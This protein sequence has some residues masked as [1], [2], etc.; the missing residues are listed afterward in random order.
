MWIHHAPY[1]LRATVSGV[2]Q[3]PPRLHVDVYSLME[4]SENAGEAVLHYQSQL[5]TTI[6]RS[7]EAQILAFEKLRSSRDTTMVPHLLVY[8]AVHE[9][10]E[11]H[12]LDLETQVLV[13]RIGL[14]LS[15]LQC[16]NKI[17]Q[18]DGSSLM[19]GM[20]DVNQ[21][22]ASKDLS[23]VPAE[24][25]NN[26]R[27]FF[28]SYD[29]QDTSDDTASTS[30]ND[31]LTHIWAQTRTGELCFFRRGI[32]QWSHALAWSVQ[33]LFVRECQTTDR[34]AQLC[35]IVHMDKL[36]H[37]YDAITGRLLKKWSIIDSDIVLSDVRHSGVY[38]VL[39]LNN[40]HQ[41][42][43]LRCHI[44][45]ELPPYPRPIPVSNSVMESVSRAE[46]NLDSTLDT[47]EQQLEIKRKRI[48]HLRA[49]LISKSEIIQD[50]QDLM[51]GPLR[52]VFMV[53]DNPISP[54]DDTS[55]AVG[56][57]LLQRK[58]EQFRKRILERLVPIIGSTVDSG[59]TRA[60][61]L[62][63]TETKHSEVK[64]MVDILNCSSGWISHHDGCTIWLGAEFKNLSK[65]TLFN[66]RLSVSQ[67]ESCGQI[68]SSLN[69]A[70]TSRLIAVVQVSFSELKDDEYFD[71]S[72]AVSRILSS[73]VLL[74]VDQKA[75]VTDDDTLQH[76]TFMMTM[77][78]VH[79]LCPESWRTLLETA[80]LTF[81][82]GCHLNNMAR[83]RLAVLLRDGLGLCS[84][85]NENAFGSLEAGIVASITRHVP[86]DDQCRD[87][88]WDILFRART[89]VQAIEYARK[90][91]LLSSR[92]A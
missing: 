75:A 33:D 43:P 62:D 2:D 8:D 39:V 11:C 48:E 84:S 46:S 55:G 1:F 78:S 81:N 30:D 59:F 31:A 88:S 44:Y 37:L 69:P 89:E 45:P 6:E 22:P 26:L 36:S 72:L 12:R 27:R 86:Q 35:L 74:H 32:L 51:R 49:S 42:I 4:S 67:R 28:T 3:T 83:P 25:T 68:L 16:S 56:P 47:L 65:A 79:Q 71:R 58:R 18:T 40:K 54:S 57:R 82:V 7:K 90:V 77:P 64:P 53:G 14:D 66:L 50:C 19:S 34:V 20:L 80:I 73:A 87:S 10:L 9:Q 41:Q 23:S 21:L 5:S 70:A 92:F 61:E 24:Y 85:N 63:E 15:R 13:A 60:N 76:N 17:V 91:V 29:L 38:S 52:S